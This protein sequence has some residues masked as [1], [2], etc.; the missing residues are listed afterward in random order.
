MTNIIDFEPGVAEINFEDTLDTTNKKREEYELNLQEKAGIAPTKDFKALRDQLA[1]QEIDKQKD[2]DNKLIEYGLRHGTM[3]IKTA[4]QVLNRTYFPDPELALERAAAARETENSVMANPDQAEIIAVD[5]DADTTEEETRKAMYYQRWLADLHEYSDK[6]GALADTGDLIMS[7]LP[8]VSAGN[9][10]KMSGYSESLLDEKYISHH[11]LAEGIRNSLRYAMANL[12]SEEFKQYLNTVTA[13]IQAKNPNRFM[14]DDY[15]HAAEYGGSLIV[16][17]AAGLEALGVGG[18][19]KNISKASTKTF[20]KAVLS[21]GSVLDKLKFLLGTAEKPV[22]QQLPE[23]TPAH[24]ASNDISEELVNRARQD[25]YTEGLEKEQEEVL[26]ASAIRNL[27][28]TFGKE[29]NEPV[30]TSI[31]YLEDGNVEISYLL[32]DNSGRGYTAETAEKMQKSFKEMGVDV[33][34]DKRD[35]TGSYLQFTQVASEDELDRLIPISND[36]RD[37]IPGRHT[38]VIGKVLEAPL[39]FIGRHLSG[40]TMGSD[41][42]HAKDIAATR[43]YNALLNR[44]AV[45]YKSTFNT[46]DKEQRNLLTDIATAGNSASVWYT[47]DYLR[48][49]GC[50]E[51]AIKA[52]HDYREIEDTLWYV[53]NFTTRRELSKRGVKLYAGKYIGKKTPLRNDTIARARIITENGEVIDNTTVLMNKDKYNLIKLDPINTTDATHLVVP[54]GEELVEGSLPL[55]LLPYKAGGRREYLSGTFFIRVAGDIKDAG[56]NVVGKRIRTI[57]TANSAADGAKMADEINEVIKLIDE[58]E[59]PVEGTKKLEALDLQFFKVRRWEDVQELIDGGV[60]SSRGQAQSMIDGKKFVFKETPDN[61]VEAE[62]WASDMHI[63][64]SSFNKKRGN[65]LDDVLGSKTTFYN[66]NEMFDKAIRKASAIAG[67]SDLMLWYKNTL[68]QYRSVIS[69]WSEIEIMN[70]ISAIRNAKIAE[71]IGDKTMTSLARSAKNFLAHAKSIANARTPGQ[72]AVKNGMNELAYQFLK[73]PSTTSKKIGSYLA[74][75]DPVNVAQGLVFNKSMGWYSPKQAIQQS[76]GTAAVVAMEPVHATKAITALPVLMRSSLTGD[77][78]PLAKVLGLSMDDTKRLIEFMYKFGTKES[79]GLLTG[80]EQLQKKIF[81]GDSTINKIMDHQYDFMRWGNAFNYYV[82]DIAAFLAK[83]NGSFRDIAA[84]SDDL[85]LN[86]TRSSNAGIQRGLT[87]PL[88][89]WLTYP[90]RWLEAMGNKRLSKKQRLSLIGSQL[91]LFGVGGVGGDTLGKW[92]YGW[93]DV[94]AETK[95]FIGEGAMGLLSNEIGV[96]LRDGPKVLNTLSTLKENFT[97]IKKAA[98]ASVMAYMYDTFDAAWEFI[99]VPFT[100]EQMIEWAYKQQRT[101]KNLP[102]GMKT[103]TKA[104]VMFSMDKIMNYKGVSVQNPSATQ[105]LFTALGY[106]P[107]ENYHAR[108][109]ELMNMDLQEAA[110]EHVKSFDDILYRIE[111]YN[112]IDPTKAMQDEN[113]KRLVEEYKESYKLITASMF[114]MYGKGSPI[115]DMFDRALINRIYKSP[116]D[117][118]EAT[119]KKA[120]STLNNAQ[121]ALL[122]EILRGE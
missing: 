90:M 41:V 68:K 81:K 82:A 121:K 67:R 83:R 110:Q 62:D 57:A 25:I 49:A 51:D 34:I 80:A 10:A 99:K 11:G 119:E 12:N 122:F 114:N 39:A 103:A 77:Y 31:N 63:L 59:N 35:D 115:Y 72:E 58:V 116:A 32:G 50:N 76:L 92:I 65:V 93:D 84:Y 27:N 48:K 3:D 45:K 94:D 30:D 91:A 17:S 97:D 8:I 100:D 85:F 88:T 95:T 40:S 6:Q 64:N 37:W 104:M 78:K 19:V 2:W 29:F 47:D 66:I 7:S 42:S 13:E 28:K 9:V 79:A 21:K 52:Y 33:D 60:L 102:S 106:N 73:R 1:Q 44:Y 54:A 46:L 24:I 117:L 14:L 4:Q 70:P 69:N 55:N 108:M 15:I 26:K 56:G 107:N 96:D 86:M 5:N 61:V 98:S 74:D 120:E 87:A 112:L 18:I 105:K 71:N 43:W 109:L 16:D 53:R 36:A 118:T 111:R 22:S 101:G 75:T 20:T 113:Y 38:P 89:Q 23:V